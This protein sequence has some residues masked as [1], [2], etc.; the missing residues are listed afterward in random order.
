MKD[1]RRNRPSGTKGAAAHRSQ[2]RLSRRRF[3]PVMNRNEKP[4]RRWL[5]GSLMATV[6]YIL[7]P[8]SWWNDLVVNLP[9]AYAVGFLLGLL[10]PNLFLPGMIV[11]YWLTNVAGLILL[12]YGLA[13][14]LSARQ[15]RLSRRELL[16]DLAISILYTLFVVALARIGWLEFP[17]DQLPHR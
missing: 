13:N 12:H 7:S 1:S 4:K 9:L 5:K 15:R 14:V 2:P 16:K 3:L 10:S 6:G 17:L 11:G 8:L